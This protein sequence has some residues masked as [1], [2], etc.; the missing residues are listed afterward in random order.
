MSI[1]SSP[2]GSL[3]SASISNDALA[4]AAE[5]R[6]RQATPQLTAAQLAAEHEK[7]QKFRR[8]IDP[9]I[10]RPN[11]RDQAMSS[12]KTLLT[13]SE[14]LLREPENLKFQQFKPTNTIIKRD[15]VDR[16]GAL[17]FA[18]ELGFKPEVKNFQPYYTFHR[19][20]LEDLRIGATILQEY[21][22]LETEKEERVARAKKS[23]K[24][25]HDDAAEKV[26]LAFMD[27]RKAKVLRDEIEKEQR[28]ARAAAA[29]RQAALE[30]AESLRR[31]PSPKALCPV[32][33]IF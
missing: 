13:I 17:E 16:K 2:S 9:G 4:A 18:I 31:P 23:E 21:I 22:T 19:R 28:A 3:N 12:L 8:L 11:P 14:N 33:V 6:T 24:A 29:S 25:A 30:A 1:P 27:D 5:R 10:T 26:K 20:H 32:Q 7:R 15:L